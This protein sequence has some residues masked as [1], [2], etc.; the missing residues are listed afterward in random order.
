MAKM[1]QKIETGGM[2]RTTIA[3][4]IVRAV[5]SPA[6]VRAE[7]QSGH[8]ASAVSGHAAV[9][10]ASASAT[11]KTGMM[12]RTV[13]DNFSTS[14]MLWRGRPFGRGRDGLR[15][16]RAQPAR[17]EAVGEDDEEQADADGERWDE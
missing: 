10:A 2:S 16:S 9:S 13:L 7:R 15:L 8:C 14:L 3:V 5:W 1:A 4:F 6:F 12:R 11:A 17:A